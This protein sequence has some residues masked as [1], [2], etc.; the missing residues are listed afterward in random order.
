MKTKEFFIT[1]RD[2]QVV[3][4]NCLKDQIQSLP[5]GRYIFKIEDKSIRTLQQNKYLHW[6]FTLIKDGFRDLGYN[7][8]RTTEDAKYIMKDMF[9]KY[10]IENG[11]GGKIQ[12]VK[13][14]RDLT[15][16]EMA[17][18]IEDCI[19]FSAENLNTVIPAPNEQI[20]IFAA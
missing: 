10:F 19:Q 1:M 11:T 18:F 6:M 4:R 7:E 9:L 2:K 20:E 16:E 13:R 17:V 12:M 8:V 15:K 14:T 5:D 3:N